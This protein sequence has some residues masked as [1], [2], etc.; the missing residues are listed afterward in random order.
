MRISNR[1]RGGSEHIWEKHWKTAFELGKGAAC[2]ALA[3]LA[4]ESRRPDALK[5][6]DRE[7]DELTR[8]RNTTTL[9][10]V[11]CSQLLGMPES[12]Q[13]E[14]A[15]KTTA[16]AL[17]YFKGSDFIFGVRALFLNSF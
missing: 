8:T 5:V 12:L 3:S 15:Q 7:L 11:A 14:A 16:L 4:E 2:G 10:A 17:I 9:A 13:T 6:H 1:R